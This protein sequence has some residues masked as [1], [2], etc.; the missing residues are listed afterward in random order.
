MSAS[1]PAELRQIRKLIDGAIG[2]KGVVFGPAGRSDR[3][4]I[5]IHSGEGR[6]GGWT[7]AT[8]DP[9]Q[10]LGLIEKMVAD[11][12]DATELPSVA[13]MLSAARWAQRY[14]IERL[15]AEAQTL[16]WRIM[17]LES[18]QARARPYSD[19]TALMVV[20]ERRAS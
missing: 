16:R 17:H 4:H 9:P 11:L 8:M 19:A 10:W 13:S 18:E 1:T 20:A 7:S 14:E 2:R 3:I 12:P 5:A 6:K 15:T